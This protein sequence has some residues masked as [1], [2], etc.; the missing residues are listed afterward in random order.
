MRY[1][2]IAV[3]IC[4]TLSSCKYGG[5][6][7]VIVADTSI[8]FDL[9]F[10]QLFLDS[11]DIEAYVE[12]NP[13]FTSF[14]DSYFDFYKERNFSYAWLDEDGMGEQAANF[15]NLLDNLLEEQRDS[16]IY[17]KRL[18][19]LYD[20][21]QLI[22]SPW[23]KD[24][25]IEKFTEAELLLTGQF[26]RYATKVYAGADMDVTQ[27]GWF[28][29]R[30]KIILTNVL[31]SLIQNKGR[32]IEQYEPLNK[33]YRRLEK[34]LVRYYEIEKNGRW[35]SITFRQKS[36]QIGDSSEV[37]LQIKNRLFATGDLPAMDSSLIFDSSLHKAIQQFQK[38][39][40]WTASGKVNSSLMNDLNTPI[41]E[42][43]KKILINME[44]ARWMPAEFSGDFILVNIPEFKLHVYEDGT[45]AY[46]M[47]VVVGK[48]ADNTVI[49]NGNISYL[50]FSPSWHVPPG[51]LK[52][53]VLP[54]IQKDPNYLSKH[55][56]VVEKYQGNTPIAVRQ[57]PGKNNPL[58]GVKF[59][60][61]NSH[62]IYLHDTNN[63]NA[64]KQDKRSLSHGCIR[65]SDPEKLAVFALKD[66]PNFT[67]DS[68]R[69]SMKSGK[70]QYVTLKR[71]IPVLI[72]YFTAWVDSEGLLHIRNDLYGHDEKMA[73]KLF[74]KPQ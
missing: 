4:Y 29:P 62:N 59:M 21:L 23:T 57:V 65:V 40:G 67:L 64:F 48:Q 1:W 39:H 55:N 36:Y 71:K 32:A 42:K 33:H 6:Q 74:T 52:K 49:F 50:V 27:L 5:S 68:I 3:C 26:F 35:D 17:E 9:A 19:P 10:N 56:M 70:E 51:I 12:M 47:P 2:I 69:T 31:D 66:Q 22:P 63:K 58:G 7:K 14:R 34:M 37:I 54:G 61:P 18:R 41:T 46:D 45:H 15:M 72:T 8:T 25:T 38:R 20:S 11:A 73:Q 44:R 13:S 28:I 24:V 16:S 30:K 43:I 60:F 53:E